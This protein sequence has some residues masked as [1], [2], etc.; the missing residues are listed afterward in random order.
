[1]GHGARAFHCGEK[2]GGLGEAAQEA[3]VDRVAVAVVEAHEEV[4]GLEFGAAHGEILAD[5]VHTPVFL[6]E[7]LVGVG[8]DEEAIL[9]VLIVD[10]V[11]K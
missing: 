3:A 11:G 4:A 10:G 6:A 9:V 5:E 2:R 1:M 8:D 7:G